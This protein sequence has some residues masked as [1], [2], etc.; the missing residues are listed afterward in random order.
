W[1][2]RIFESRIIQE[3][4]E[5]HWFVARPA[6]ATGG[7]QSTSVPVDEIE[8]GSATGGMGTAPNSGGDPIMYAVMGNTGRGGGD[9]ARV[10]PAPGLQ[11]RAV[12][13][14]AYKG[15][16]WAEKG[17]EVAIISITDTEGLTAAFLGADGFAHPAPSFYGSR[18][19]SARHQTAPEKLSGKKKRRTGA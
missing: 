13:R 11:V 12:V 9:L 1:I 6:H 8:A 19:A 4:C 10:L 15:G 18:G 17:C 2:V 16:S 14:D 7:K 3:S 5:T